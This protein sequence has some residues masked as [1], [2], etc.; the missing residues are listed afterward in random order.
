MICISYLMT[1]YHVGHEPPKIGQ[2]NYSI[3]MWLSQLL[4]QKTYLEKWLSTRIN[5]FEIE[6]EIN[7]PKVTVGGSVYQYQ[8]NHDICQEVEVM[9]SSGFQKNS[10]KQKVP[11]KKMKDKK[12][13]N[14]ISKR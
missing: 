6:N 3:K 7:G 2:I 1:L 11:L 9:T 4:K 13:N 8:L 10:H 5:I 12:L 14:N